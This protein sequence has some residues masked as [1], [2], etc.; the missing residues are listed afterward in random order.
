MTCLSRSVI[1]LFALALVATAPTATAQAVADTL[2]TWDAYSAEE[3]RCQ[4]RIFADPAEKY[5]HTVVVR[6]LSSNR[7]TSTV[8]D[9]P[10]I[11]EAVARSFD[12]DPTAVRWVFHWGDFSYEGAV[13]SGKELFLRASFRWTKAHKLSSPRWAVLARADVEAF[14][15]RHFQ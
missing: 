7:G 5:T 3:A 12:L 15:D 9:A 10:F 13:T 1:A 4:V 8:D 14:T 11:A 6:E 2:F